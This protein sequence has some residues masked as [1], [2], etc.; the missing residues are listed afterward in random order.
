MAKSIV[1]RFACAALAG[2]LL[3]A[4]LAGCM[5]VDTAAN[6]ELSANRQYMAA[7]N[8]GMDDL[9]AKLE[10]FND[11]VARGDVVTMR[12]QVEKAFKELDD[13]ESIEAPEVLADVKAG[14][15]EGCAMLEEALG[16]Y[17]DLYTQL[18]SGALAADSIEYANA[19]AEIQAS[20]D[21]GIAK[22]EETDQKAL[23]L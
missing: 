11:A 13:L 15:A 6:D 1:S 2:A 9:A 14:Y 4:A 5:P 16:S 7:V 8:Q 21:A 23:E 20:Y 17:V 10:S 12:T 22:L 3:T 18:E 19:L